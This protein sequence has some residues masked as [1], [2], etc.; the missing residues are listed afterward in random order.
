M[1]ICFERE[2][3]REREREGEQERLR[4]EERE[5]LKRISESIMYTAY[6]DL[7]SISLFL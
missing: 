6:I 3:E 4:E 5:K 2:R 1:H 7:S